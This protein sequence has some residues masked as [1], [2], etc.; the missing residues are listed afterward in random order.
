MHQTVNILYMS[1]HCTIS[2]RLVTLHHYD[3][4]FAMLLDDINSA[5]EEEMKVSSS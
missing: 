3:Y 2:R 1:L 4:D 5:L